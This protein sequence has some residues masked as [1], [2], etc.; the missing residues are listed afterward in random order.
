[1]QVKGLGTALKILF[2]DSFVHKRGSFLTRDEIV[3][4]F[5]G[6]G[7]LSDSIYQLDNFRRMINEEENSHQQQQ[8]TKPVKKFP[9]GGLK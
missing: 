5:N 6:F 7:R 2:A 9:F 8:P 4:L 1:M 3:A